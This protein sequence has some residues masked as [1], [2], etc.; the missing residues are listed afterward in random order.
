MLN[1]MVGLDF[2]YDKVKSAFLEFYMRKSITLGFFEIV[3]DCSLIDGT[4][5][6]LNE[7]MEPPE[8]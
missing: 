5:S 1:L 3:E 7:C 4:G 6:L 8:P 2:S